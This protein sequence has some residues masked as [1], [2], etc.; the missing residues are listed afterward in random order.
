MSSAVEAGGYELDIDLCDFVA[1][2]SKQEDSC[3]LI[4]KNTRGRFG[5]GCHLAAKYQ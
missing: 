4:A 3:M 5:A 2:C 1:G